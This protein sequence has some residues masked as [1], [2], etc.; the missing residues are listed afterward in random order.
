MRRCLKISSG[1]AAVLC[2]LQGWRAEVR[3][4]VRIRPW[5]LVRRVG[6]VWVTS[7]NYRAAPRPKWK[8]V[9]LQNTLFH[10]NLAGADQFP[11]VRRR[12]DDRVIETQYNQSLVTTVISSCA[13]K[14]TQWGLLERRECVAARQK[15]VLIL[16]YYPVRWRQE[17]KRLLVFRCFLLHH[18]S[19]T[20]PTGPQ[21]TASRCSSQLHQQLVWSSANTWSKACKALR[22]L[23]K[24]TCFWSVLGLYSNLKYL[25]RV[26]VT[27]IP[28]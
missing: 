13:T 27:M 15:R 8:G 23:L 28:V 25:W 18:S 22:L 14:W 21:L 10:K 19:P 12:A 6:N 5:S 1:R 4:A 2:G 9:I 16:R 11:C 24:L 3:G 17:A 20:H 26:S 7:A